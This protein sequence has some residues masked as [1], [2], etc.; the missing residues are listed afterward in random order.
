MLL[1]AGMLAKLVG[2][3]LALVADLLDSGVNGSVIY[4]TGWWIKLFGQACVVLGCLVTSTCPVEDLDLD[5]VS[6]WVLF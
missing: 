4:T 6:G 1:G 3:G 2:G 5:Q